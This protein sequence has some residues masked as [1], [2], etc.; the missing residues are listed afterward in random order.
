MWIY[1]SARSSLRSL[2]YTNSLLLLTVMSRKTR[3]LIGLCRGAQSVV[4]AGIKLQEDSLKTIWD[5]SSFKS[6]TKGCYSKNV[7]AA[8]LKNFDEIAK[9]L[10]ESA[11]RIDTV[12]YGIREFANYTPTTTAVAATLK[13]AG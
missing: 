5:N 8:N 9:I 10:N 4:E 3:E 6:L 1:S 11:A 7:S 2:L 13:N 12:L